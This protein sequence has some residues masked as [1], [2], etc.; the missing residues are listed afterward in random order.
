MFIGVRNNTCYYSRMPK[1]RSWTDEELITA[2][3]ESRSVRGVIIKLKLVPAGGNYDQINEKIKNLGIST[4]H[5][6]GKGW[7]KNWE[8]DPRIP[9]M[10][11]E[12]ILVDGKRYQSHG[13]K[14]RLFLAGLKEPKCEICGWCEISDDG[15]VPVELDHIN[16]RHNDNRIQNLRILCPNCHS[17]QITHRGRNKKVALVNKDSKK[18]L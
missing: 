2:V 15:R 12:D 4:E 11:L 5:F 17:L 6:T 9:K 7:N 18:L 16:G 13:L 8:F 1:K 10:K 14:K 3:K